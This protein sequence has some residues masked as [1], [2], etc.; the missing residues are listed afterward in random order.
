MPLDSSR[1]Y[2]KRPRL[3]DK[4]L[5]KGIRGYFIT[6][7]TFNRNS[8]FLKPQIVDSMIK[9][10]AEVSKKE[11]FEVVVYC[12]MPD[13]VHLTLTGMKENSDLQKFIKLFV[14]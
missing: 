4:D 8:Y 2:P 12:F 13:H 7:T 14:R 9:Y 10:L 3:L 11:K 5:Y 6:I 1:S